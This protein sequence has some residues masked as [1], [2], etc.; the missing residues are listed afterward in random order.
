MPRARSA[1]TSPHQAPGAQQVPPL[2]GLGHGLRGERDRAGYLCPE[3]T[4]M[5]PLWNLGYVI[6]PPAPQ[7]KGAARN[8]YFHKGH[9]S[10]QVPRESSGFL[11]RL[12]N[13]MCQT[14]ATRIIFPL[15]L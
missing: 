1:E 7:W 11:G 5:T 6:D 3:A 8:L 14:R 4:M 2:L 12:Y 9:L 15:G 13:P 10:Y